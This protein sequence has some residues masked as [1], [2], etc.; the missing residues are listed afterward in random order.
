M[1]PLWGRHDVRGPHIPTVQ[2]AVSAAE[3]LCHPSRWH[4]LA[5]GLPAPSGE[6]MGGSRSRRVPRA[7]RGHRPAGDRLG[8]LSVTVT[9][10]GPVEDALGTSRNQ[11]QLL[12]EPPGGTMGKMSWC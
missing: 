4:R 12:E 3:R 8:T 5:A 10:G 7:V 2:G 6:P 9:V 1:S 11:L